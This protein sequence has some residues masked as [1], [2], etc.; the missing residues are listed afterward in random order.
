MPAVAVAGALTSEMRGRHPA[1]TSD[2]DC[3]CR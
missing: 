1:L 3:S 2:R